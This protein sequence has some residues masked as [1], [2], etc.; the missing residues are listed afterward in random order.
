MMIQIYLCYFCEQITVFSMNLFEC[1]LFNCLICTS[2]KVLVL[3]DLK[4]ASKHG[5]FYS[6]I[7]LD[8][9][10]QCS[11][12]CQEDIFATMLCHLKKKD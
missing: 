1:G 11:H 3:T 6:G 8:W 4:I 7:K 9:T 5:N 2:R 12:I 10:L